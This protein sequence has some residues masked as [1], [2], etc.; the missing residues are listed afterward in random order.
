MNKLPLT[1]EEFA[2]LQNGSK[3]AAISDQPLVISNRLIGGDVR[4]LDEVALENIQFKDCMFIGHTMFNVNLKGIRFI[5]CAFSAVRWEGGRWFDLS[6][7]ECAFAERDVSIVPGPGSGGNSNFTSCV[8]KGTE[9]KFKK[10]SELLE[11]NG[12]ICGNGKATFT[13]CKLE[14]FSVLVDAQTEFSRCKMNRL[15]I[16]TRAKSGA[17]SLLIEDS[18]SLHVLDASSNNIQTV[19]LRNSSFHR[20]DA[21]RLQASK[22]VTLENVTGALD[23]MYVETQKMAAVLCRFSAPDGSSAQGEALNIS[24]AE[25]STLTLEQCTFEGRDARIDAEGTAPK[26]D[27]NG[28]IIPIVNK[29]T[30]KTYSY[31]TEIGTLSL[32]KTHLTD[33]KFS[34]SHIKHLQIEDATFSATRL[35]H[36]EIG[37]LTLKNVKLGG[38]LDFTN[39]QVK[40]VITENVSREPSLTIVKDKTTELKL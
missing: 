35:P 28:K 15:A 31:F 24:G 4:R 26:R 34:Y 2:E 30:G 22:E 12:K 39:T 27:S 33:A 19:K 9:P 20:F 36:S 23:F 6:F 14:R 37:K 38:T 18:E 8:F 7:N 5:R 16:E 10:Q 40:E 29:E 11:W 3:R 32:R 13:D 25:I 21:N 17:Q 1:D